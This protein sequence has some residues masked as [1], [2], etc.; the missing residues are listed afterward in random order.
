MFR[1]VSVTTTTVI[2]RQHHDDAIQDVVE[3]EH[4]EP[5]SGTMRLVR[6]QRRCG[7]RF[8][9]SVP[10]PLRVRTRIAAARKP[11]KKL[12]REL[13]DTDSDVS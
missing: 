7:R 10:N 5:D 8:G 3:I 12:P 2:A 6:H 13:V 9:Y 11:L 4:F 1:Q